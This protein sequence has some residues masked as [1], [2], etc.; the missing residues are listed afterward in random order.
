MEIIGATISATSSKVHKYIRLVCYSY[1]SGSE[2]Y[3]KIALLNRN[4]RE[5]LPDSG[6]LDQKKVLKFKAL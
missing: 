1:L 2:L 6:L 5:L 3:H 4:T